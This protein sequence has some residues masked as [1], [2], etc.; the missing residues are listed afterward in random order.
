MNQDLITAGNN[1]ED[2]AKFGETPCAATTPPSPVA[3][4]TSSMAVPTTG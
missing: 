1:Y 3:T 4:T 2:R